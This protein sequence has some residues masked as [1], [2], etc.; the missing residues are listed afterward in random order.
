[1]KRALAVL[2][3]TMLVACS[4]FGP[5]EARRYYVLDAS[6]VAAVP[7]SGARYAGVLLVAP[8][9]V[10]AFYD[11]EDI[12]YSKAAGQ[13][14]YY[15]HS[16]WTEPPGRRLALL[17]ARRLDDSGRFAVVAVAGL[18]VRGNLM[19]ATHLEELYHDATAVPGQARIALVAELIDPSHRA[20]IARRS[21][22][23]A[24]PLATH[25]A[26]GTADACGRALGAILD[27]VVAWSADQAARFGPAR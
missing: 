25:D 4:A 23:S 11:T 9:T 8:P 20:L 16:A 5:G 18:G 19:L 2:L 17:L 14:A 26:A 6:E 15:Q 10:A 1:M 22:S 7:E 12:A 27:E 24:V 21:F 3:V 13:R